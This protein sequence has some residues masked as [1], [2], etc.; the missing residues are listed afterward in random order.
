MN[1]SKLLRPLARIPNWVNSL[2][3]AACVGI[4]IGGFAA[5]VG[6]EFATDYWRAS[7]SKTALPGFC[8]W[9][10][11]HMDLAI[12][13][14]AIAWGLYLWHLERQRQRQLQGARS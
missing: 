14:S 3:F 13:G 10:C 6:P 11:D 8:R 12:A 5:L 7:C 9:G 4:S 2:Q 1:L